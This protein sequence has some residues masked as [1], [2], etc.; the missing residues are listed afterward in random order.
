MGELVEASFG[1]SPTD[2]PVARLL[3]CVVVAVQRPGSG[4]VRLG[5]CLV[6]FG[7]PVDLSWL[8]SAP[9]L[10]APLARRGLTGGLSVLLT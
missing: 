3:R 7:R 6:L 4:A 10:L 2:A 5:S 8:R 1:T 9:G